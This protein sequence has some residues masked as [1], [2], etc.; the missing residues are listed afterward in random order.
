M[1]EEYRALAA[2]LSVIVVAVLLRVI[3]LKRGIRARQVLLLPLSLLLAVL[4]SVLA[5][6]YFDRLDFSF[7]PFLSGCEILVWNL[8]I[9]GVFLI[10]KLILLPI[11]KLLGKSSERMQTTVENWYEYS[12]AEEAWFL[13]KSCQDLRI[14]WNCM[15]VVT[16]VICAASMAVISYYGPTSLVWLR[17]FPCAALIVVNEIFCFLN[18]YTLEEYLRDFGGEGV[19]ASRISN[20]GKLRALY[21]RL[22]PDSLLVARSGGV[23]SGQE[24]AGRLLRELASSSDPADRLLSGYFR[25]LRRD[26]GVF[27]IDMIGAAAKLLHRES[28]VVLDPFYRDLSDY[29]LLPMVDCLMRN[30]KCL[31]IVGRETHKADATDWAESILRNYSHTRALW[32]VGLLSHEEPDCEVGVLSFSQI[33][34]LRVQRTNLAFFDGTG[35]VLLLEPSRMLATSQVG[36]GLLV[37]KMNRENPPVYFICDHESDGLVDTLSHVLQV[38]ITNVVAAPV[39]KSSFTAMGW[40]A[41]GEYD[42]QKLFDKQTH[43]LGNGVELAA[44]ALKYQVPKVSWYGADKAPVKDIRWLAGQYYPQICKYA[45]LPAQQDT[46][47]EKIAF[48]SNL[49]EAPMERDAFVIAEDEFC[50]L[51]ATMRAFITRGENQSFVN[52][53]SENYLLRDYMRFNPQMFMNDPKVVPAIAPHYAKTERNTVFRLLLMMAIAPVDED[54]IAH[55]LSLLG[56]H[57]DDVYRAFSSLVRRYTCTDG[58]IIHINNDREINAEMIPVQVNRFTIPQKVFDEHFANTLKNAYI[59]VE[60]EKLETDYIDARLFEHLTQNLMP[61]QLVTYNGKLYKVQSLNPQIGCILHRA[62]DDYTERLYYRQLRRYRFDGT[63]ELV[64]VRRL[65]DIEIASEQRSIEVVSTGYLQMHNNCDLRTARLVDLSDDPSIDN[66]TR[67]YKN[68]NV[69]RICLPETDEETRFT[70]T[71]LLNELFHTIFPD[72][73]PYL[74][75]L[76]EDLPRVEGAINHF[77]SHMEGDYEPGMIYVVE[78]SDMDLGLLEVVDNELPRFFDILADYLRWHFEK[79]REPDKTYTEPQDVLLPEEKKKLSLLQQLLRRIGLIARDDPEKAEEDAAKKTKE[80]KI[81]RRKKEEQQEKPADNEPEK[82]EEAPDK[83]PTILAQDEEEEP[84]DKEASLD[85]VDGAAPAGLSAGFDPNAPAED[86]NKDKGSLR[87]V[88]KKEPAPEISMELPAEEPSDEDRIVLHGDDDGSIVPNSIPD[89]LD[90][91]M[92]IKPSRYQR[93][94]YLLFG[95]EEFDEHIALESVKSFLSAHGWGENA[96]TR[97]RKPFVLDKVNMTLDPVNTCDFCGHPITGV[98]FEK[99]PDGRVRCSD[100]SETAIDG[101]E[102][103][104]DLFQRTEMMMENVFQIGVNAS[105]RVVTT[106]ARTIGKLTGHVFTPTNAMDERVLGFA[107]RKGGKYS[108]YVENGS[109]RLAAATTI[110]HELT[111][112]W[113]YLNWDTD[114]IR[115]L[116][117]SDLQRDLVYEGMA[118]WVSVQMLYAMGETSY[119][120]QTEKAQESRNDIYGKGF[121]LYKD[122]YGLMRNGEELMF[123][124][125]N[126]FPPL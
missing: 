123:S 81:R 90:I 122:R 119:A 11:A 115:E 7:L 25:R 79:I 100:C 103:F 6:V 8:L 47:E 82:T 87:S 121:S 92:R 120:E 66:Y 31:I 26:N 4:L 65:G 41:E 19:K 86:G 113:Q 114:K 42:R 125:F 60:D 70:L 16:A 27:N 55:E 108:I 14:V 2:V 46:L 78:D 1:S 15:A 72:A 98:S 45:N 124:P 3:N 28:V 102:A 95:F 96:L 73:W 91:L 32:R 57:T 36:L 9:V 48:R 64:H 76:S 88:T 106:D 93:E 17:V 24:S 74:T 104:T 68:K 52:V 85:T 12:E 23:L 75:V 69:L 116:Y 35:M 50:N 80:K 10:L 118:V 37:E 5:Y 59:V 94:C 22:F 117:P 13:K 29:V 53:L 67:R 44:V 62:A 112:I 18:G 43:F 71:L 63:A 40:A 58:T 111:H 51:F 77:V 49:W 33:Y 101:T 89:D 30:R 105:V 107:Q 20:Y 56:Y 61:G 54:Y 34:D 97:A 99:L 21:E 83:P 38:N 110:A 39:P 126:T 84:H 109:P